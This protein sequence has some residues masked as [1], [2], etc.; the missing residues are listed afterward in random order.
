MTREPDQPER[1]CEPR[2]GVMFRAGAFGGDAQ[3]CEMLVTN[4]SP[5]GLTARCTRAKHAGER[6]R[7]TLPELGVVAAEVRWTLGE[8]IGVRFDT[9]VD[10]ASYYALIAAAIAQPDRSNPTAASRSNR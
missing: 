10:R 5:H 3:P 6:L 8:Q 7:V 2:D 9:P 1:R 4:L